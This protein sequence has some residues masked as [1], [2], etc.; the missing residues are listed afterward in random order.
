[1]WDFAVQHSMRKDIIS[2][3]LI[4]ILRH[5]QIGDIEG[6]SVLRVSGVQGIIVHTAH[7]YLLWGPYGSFLDLPA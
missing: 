5:S 6:Q 2:Y 3:R 1:M 4:S 7:T